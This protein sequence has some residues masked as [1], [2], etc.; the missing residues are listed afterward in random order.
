MLTRRTALV[1]RAALAR[2]GQL[3]RSGAPPRRARLRPRSSRPSAVR[4]RKAQDGPQAALCR[5]LPC[6]CGCGRGP[7]EAHHEPPRSRGGKDEDAVPLVREC[8]EERH[9]TTAAKFW[10]G[11]GRDPERIK[12]DLQAQLTEEGYP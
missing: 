2:G 3:R 1:R 11:R 9:R 8:H 6:G 10:E 7:S 5:T 12:A 4:R